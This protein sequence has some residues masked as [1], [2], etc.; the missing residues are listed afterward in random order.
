MLSTQRM[1]RSISLMSLCQT[2][3]CNWSCSYTSQNSR[4]QYETETTDH[5][6]HTHIH[7]RTNARLIRFTLTLSSV[8][9]GVTLQTLTP[10]STRSVDTHCLLSLALLLHRVYVTLIDITLTPPPCP[11]ILTDTARRGVTPGGTET[12]GTVLSTVCAK[13]PLG[14]IWK[15]K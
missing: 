6:T 1:N 10:V 9:H 5:T 15:G 7:A 4:L 12:T 11:A 2:A 3:V 14:A 13:R 8:V